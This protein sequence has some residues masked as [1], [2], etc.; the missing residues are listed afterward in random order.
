MPGRRLDIELVERKLAA[1]RS[2]A[3]RAILDGK[4]AVD[5]VPA[6]RPGRTVAPGSII[7]V[8][9][10]LERYVGRGAHKLEAA[11]AAFGVEVAGRSAVD[12]GAATGGFTDVLLQHG[13]LS[14]AAVD[15]G[16]GQLHPRLRAD[17]RV[18][19]FE[20]CNIRGTAPEDVGGPFDLVVADLS[21][22]S[23]RV[24]AGALAALGRED[25]DWV[26]LLKPQFEVGRDAIGRTGV[27]RSARGRGAAACRVAADF[28]EVGLRVVGAAPSPLL[29]GDGNR[30]ALLWLR[31]DG[32]YAGDA[33][34]YKVLADE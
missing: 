24:V 25:A 1:S 27:V 2:G 31:R 9:E 10:D 4:V 28:A 34:L 12:I 3:R 11:I 17:L 33:Q 30:E 13:A 19:V 7:G 15:V 8:T 6:T 29:G 20:G 21:F 14:V 26:L 22:I 18:A 32:R 16:H 23:L 5:G